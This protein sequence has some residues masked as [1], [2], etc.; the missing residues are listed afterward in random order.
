MTLAEELQRE[1]PAPAIGR[2]VELLEPPLRLPFNGA[3]SVDERR[4][5]DQCSYD[6]GPVPWEDE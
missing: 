2:R 4:I 6:Y 5:A 3:L 1:A